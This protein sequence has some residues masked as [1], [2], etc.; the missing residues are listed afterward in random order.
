MTEVA[1]G[2]ELSN[3]TCLD[4]PHPP[5]PDVSDGF[6]VSESTVAILAQGTTR[7]DAVTQAYFDAGFESPR[8]VSKLIC[9][10]ES[11]GR[12]KVLFRSG[13]N[14]FSLSVGEKYHFGLVKIPFWSGKNTS[15][16]TIFAVPISNR[17]FT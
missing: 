5:P 16:E 2:T 11:F 14:T 8:M 6:V 7:A 1:R 12:A 3:P 9:T 10:C 15:A 4:A 17:I 13:K